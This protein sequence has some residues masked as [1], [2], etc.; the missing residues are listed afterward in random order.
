MDGV[1][2]DLTVTGNRSIRNG[3]IARKK[4]IIRHGFNKF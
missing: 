1:V 3:D 2:G 4:E